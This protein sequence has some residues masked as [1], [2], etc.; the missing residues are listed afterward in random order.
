VGAVSGDDL[1]LEQLRT[2]LRERAAMVPAPAGMYDRVRRAH[3]RGRVRD[4]VVAVAG[5]ATVI[6]APL[7]A[8]ALRTAR[9]AASTAT[10]PTTYLPAGGTRGPLGGDQDVLDGAATTAMRAGITPTGQSL[11]VAYAGETAGFVVTVVVG[12]MSGRDLTPMIIGRPAGSTA[13]RVLPATV[14][15]VD[16]GAAGDPASVSLVAAAEGD[17][18]RWFGIVLQPPGSTAEAVTDSTL[19]ADCFARGNRS[20]VPLHDGTALLPYTGDRRV[21]LQITDPRTPPRSPPTS[22]LLSRPTDADAALAAAVRDR[23]AVTAADA[24]IGL[25]LLRVVRDHVLVTERPSSYQVRM[26]PHP[27]ASI[28]TTQLVITRYASG[29]V[30]LAGWSAGGGGQRWL[31]TCLPAGQYAEAL[32]AVRV[33]TKGSAWMVVAPPTASLALVDFGA[34]GSGG[35]PLTDG[36]GVF[37][38]PDNATAL[39]GVQ[40]FDRKG[41]LVGRYL[42]VGTS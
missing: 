11:G 32:F 29:A 27:P 24:A 16:Y 23:G 17:A 30:T 36:M 35:L 8:N 18:G 31:W 19:R 13:W 2:A 15:G 38:H 33:G 5:L 12:R 26:L 39:T 25:R 41:G 10:G 9:P 21:W 7:G 4:L 40:A 42:P 28:G 1:L 20:P 37:A 6:A 3:R 14:S 22:Y 34:G